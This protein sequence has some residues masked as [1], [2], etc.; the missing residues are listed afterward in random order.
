LFA[1]PLMLIFI[2]SCFHKG[3]GFFSFSIITFYL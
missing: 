2:K 1:K 3:G